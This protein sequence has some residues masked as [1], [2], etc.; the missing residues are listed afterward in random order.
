[1]GQILIPWSLQYLEIS[2][3]YLGNI[4]CSILSVSKS[5]HFTMASQYCMPISV[6]IVKYI[7]QIF[8]FSLLQYLWIL[9]AIPWQYRMQFSTIYILQRPA[10][11]CQWNTNICQDCKHIGPTLVSLPLQYLRILDTDTS[12][13][14]SSWTSWGHV[15]W[16]FKFPEQYWMQYSTNNETFT[17]CNSRPILSAI[18]VPVYYVSIVTYTE[19]I[20]ICWLAC[21]NAIATG[22]YCLPAECWL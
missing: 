8:A 10:N 19:H 11:I 2:Q 6:N 17:F 7:A 22:R 1:M 9:D 15:V 12:S 16:N 3:R 21:S 4:A 5:L 13:L 20:L 14:S 18:G